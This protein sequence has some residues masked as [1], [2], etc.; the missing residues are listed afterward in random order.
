MGVRDG[1]AYLLSR[2]LVKL[3]RGHATLIRYRFYAQPVPTHSLA[4]ARASST[5]IGRLA[6]DDP[7]LKAMPRPPHV[8]ERRLRDGAHCFAASRDGVLQGFIWICEREYLE[9]EVRCLYRWSP[10]SVAAWDFDV[11]VAPEARGGRLF[12]RLWDCANA[13]MREHGYAWSLSRIST[14]NIASRAA[15]EK[16]NIQ[17]IG[18]ATFLVLGKLQVS[19]ASSLKGP[20]IAFGARAYPTLVLTPP[21]MADS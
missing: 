13:W 19:F 2:A 12:A 4:P 17:C 16:L 8:I 21:S 20:H 7:L 6:P 11:Y 3:T 9:D 15:H 10:S 14:F 1:L 18:S 5:R